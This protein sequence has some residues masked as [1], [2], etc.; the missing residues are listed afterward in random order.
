[1]ILTNYFSFPE[2]IMALLKEIITGH[3]FNGL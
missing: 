2:K 1:M 3:G